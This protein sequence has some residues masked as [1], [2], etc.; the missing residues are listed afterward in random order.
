MLTKI[1][2]NMMLQRYTGFTLL[3]CI[4]FSVLP[5]Q[6]VKKE[7]KQVRVRIDSVFNRNDSLMTILAGGKTSGLQPGLFIKCFSAFRE[8]DG[9]EVSSK[10]IGFGT[11]IE[12]GSNYAVCFISLY[13]N[14]QMVEQGDHVALNVSL[15]ALSF[16]SLLYDVS[17]NAIQFVD[18]N[19]KP[20]FDINDYIGSASKPLEDSIKSK[21]TEDLH[22][23]Y[24]EVKDR[25]GLPESM[26]R[27]MEKG[28]FKGKNG[29]QVLRDATVN[30]LNNFLLYAKTYPAKYTGN[31]YRLSE[32]FSGWV[33]SNSPFTAAEVKQALMPWYKN[34]T[35]FSGRIKE[36]KESI[37]IEGHCTSFGEDAVAL[38]ENNKMAEANQLMQFAMAVAGEIK[39][40]VG[41]ASLLVSAAQIYQDQEKYKEAIAECEKAM[42]A[43]LLCTDSRNKIFPECKK[44]E[45][46]ALI[47]KGFCQYKMSL[48]KEGLL[49]FSEAELRVKKY[50]PVMVA[51]DQDY[52]LQKIFEYQ[53][54]INYTSGDYTKAIGN[55]KKAI[56]INDVINTYDSR[57]K[58]AAY[59]KRIGNVYKDQG[60][61]RQ[62]LEVYLPAYDIYN[63]LSDEMNKWLVL[64]DIGE[65]QYYLSDY[66]KSIQY[67]DA[68]GK[69]LLALNEYD[70][71]GYASSL[72]GSNYWNMGKYDSAIFFHKRSIELR[73]MAASNAGQAFSWNQLGE[74]YQLSGYKKEALAAFDSSIV[75]Y[76]KIPD[77]AGIAGNYNSKG[78][79]HLADESYKKAAEY[80]ERSR[81]NTSKITVE[82]LYNLADA[83][84]MIDTVKSGDYLLQCKKISTETGNDM[85]KFY[86]L[87]SLSK[88]EWRNNNVKLATAY[89]DSVVI[90]SKKFATS[91]SE[92]NR[93]D[94]SAYAWTYKLEPDSAVANYKKAIALLDSTNVYGATWGR[95][96]LSDALISKGEFAEAE[97]VLLK[98]IRIADSVSAMIALGSLYNS[99]SFLY[100]LLGEF[101]KGMIANGKAATV[102]ITTGNDFRQATTFV[103]KGSLYKTTGEFKRS[104]EAYLVADSIF[105][106]AETGEM[107]ITVL[108][109][110]GVTY[111]NQGD[112][113]K[114]ID[115]FNRS[116]KYFK[117]G[118]VDENYLLNRSNIAEC[119][120]FLNRFSEAEKILLGTFPLALD[121]NINRIASAMAL[122]LGKIYFDEKDFTKAG[123]YLETA[124]DM[125]SKSGEKTKLVESLV[126]LARHRSNTG[127]EAEAER[128]LQEAV[129]VSKEY[130]ISSLSWIAFYESGLLFYRQ[131]KYDKAIDDFKN[132]VE[133][134]EKN[135]D[136]IYGG[137]ESKK[138]YRNDA[139]KVDL[140]GKLVVALAEAGKTAEAWAYANR[141]NMTGIK[142]LMGSMVNQTGDA[143]KDAALEE[144]K[145]LSQKTEALAKKEAELRAKPQT[146]QVAAQLQSIGQEKEIAEAEYIQYTEALLKKYS[147]L[148]DNFYD[149]VN[150]VDFENYKGLLP[151]D[152]AVLLYVINDNKL[153]IFSLTNEKLGI[154]PVELK[155]DISQTIREYATLL[156]IPGK[157]S[158]TGSI[159]VRTTIEGEE[160][161][162]DVSK[163]SFTDVS[164][165]M[166]RLVIS[167]VAANIA[168]K[169]KLC[170]IPNGDL[171]N[172]PFQAMGYKMPDGV[173]RFLIEDQMVFYTSRMKIFDTDPPA[174]LNLSS[175][176]VFGVPD[177]TLK[178]TEKEAQSI[179]GIMHIK[180]G[181]YIEGRATEQQAKQSLVQKKYVHFAT[182]GIL[183]YTEYNDSYL[184]FLPSADTS[185][186][187]NGKL[188]IDEIY[189]LKI[190]GCELVTLSACETAVSRQKTKGWKISPANSLLR[191]RVKSVI[192]S[193]WK[194]DDEAT[195]ILMDEFYRELSAGK[196]KGESLRLAQEKLS[197][198]TRYSHPYFWSAFVLFGDWR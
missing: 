151:A 52:Y 121:K 54:W 14:Q 125:S 9:A 147:D 92:A 176:A 113:P 174:S 18:F 1:Y 140:Y 84:M 181:M 45:I 72:T 143:G 67:L 126:Y 112:Y 153:L 97:T 185:G 166:Y 58:N 41:K 98:G 87:I 187:N 189:K 59:Y 23:T 100:A 50:K 66:T 95:I 123:Q 86:S 47:K 79:V 26:L 65:V 43:A 20:F 134:I 127:N 110:I 106:A 195:S 198:D 81:G 49:T 149:N 16:E 2:N 19:K 155:G 42:A 55:F 150:P 103:N 196:E 131:K 142:E 133:I 99:A 167:P 25:K 128:L 53:G 182:H 102:F 60:N 116:A 63:G 22:L 156:K 190:E 11:I 78:K 38:A 115:Y 77:K 27:V 62:A 194:V 173:F 152:M 177:Q 170:I 64:L 68:A 37:L 51:E 141:S 158:G 119:Y 138:I 33:I 46:A 13:N 3:F 12:S 178:Y 91:Q 183:N 164:E 132:A 74:L 57:N 101:D 172:I 191:K 71:A 135:S 34:K 165:K 35:E 76:S 48:Y 175:F 69:A 104:I 188:T 5:A 118:L 171:S 83:W 70:Y 129:K 148:K 56:Q 163:L 88:M 105:R 186:G 39:D 184:K 193:M 180:D 75:Y 120:Y 24:E 124:R 160:D 197:K 90:M 145:S 28:R 44:F 10:E 36:Y 192:A 82:A 61:Y 162:I 136:N 96:N 32:S 15:P 85:Y 30:D 21:M 89:Y 8:V 29:M 117:A 111:Y 144:A 139:R 80:F 7:T 157:A 17:L 93:L 73:K 159:H 122:T 94:L 146:E 109:N 31:V 161:N 137:E 114:A 130:N 6:E 179:A 169:K 107:R 108:N 4:C 168:G 154:T 40:T